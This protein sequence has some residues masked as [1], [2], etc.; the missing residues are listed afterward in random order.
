MVVVRSGEHGAGPAANESSLVLRITLGS[1][2]FLF[3]GDI[4]ATTEREILDAGGDVR[5]TVLKVPHH[6]SAHS[7]SAAFLDA[8]GPRVALISLGLGN[9][10]G[11]PAPAV[12]GRYAE[13]GATV[14]RTDLHGAVE[15]RTDGRWI[16]VRTARGGTSPAG[17]FPLTRP[18]K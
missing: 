1:V 5:A 10:Y 14:L 7:S 4:G 8:A 13:A 9:T 2:S 17:D 3:T 16:R 12:L 15:V 11:F 18:T 6:G